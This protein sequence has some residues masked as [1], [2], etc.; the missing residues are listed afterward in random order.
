MRTSI[1]IPAWCWDEPTRELARGALQ[2]VR[3][4][5]PA[6]EVELAMIYA[7]VGGTEELEEL[8]DVWR[9]VDPPQGWAAASNIGMLLTSGEYVVVG[10]T[11]IRVE[12]GW[13]EEMRAAASDG[14]TVVSPHDY[15]TDGVTRRKW[16]TTMRGSFWGAWY[17]FPRH[18]LDSVG[19]LDGYAMRRMADMDWAIRA[20]KLGF[21]TV[22]VPVAARH[23][24]PH[25]TLKAHPDPMDDM[26]RDRFKARHEGFDRLGSWEG[27]PR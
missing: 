27:L 18:M 14:A 9:R 19:Y 21:R 17:L 6:D 26:V 5:T 11:D 16:D 24:E 7:G 20:R 3:D 22:R 12:P 23:I 25:H 4:A 2:N 13:L 10:S 1:V 15:K 8:C